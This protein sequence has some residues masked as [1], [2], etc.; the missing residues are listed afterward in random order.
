MIQLIKQEE[1]KKEIAQIILADLPEWFGLPD[2]T[3]E[4]VQN[5]AKMP[6]WADFQ[7]GEAVGFT[8]LKETS[9]DTA[10]IYVMGVLK[11]GTGAAPGNS[12]LGRFIPMPQSTDIHFC[13][14][15]LLRRATIRNMTKPGCFTAASVFGSLS[16][17]RR[18]GMNGT[19][20][21]C[22]SWRSNR[23]LRTYDGSVTSRVVP[24][25]TALVRLI[26]PL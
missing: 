18:S 2:S 1:R 17:S 10:E 15:R 11:P 4:Y 16:V 19:R 25:P 21:R 9:P 5:S 22:S 12:C 6:F 7:D 24:S 3:A 23:I 14:S 13:R 26:F 20:V 8:A